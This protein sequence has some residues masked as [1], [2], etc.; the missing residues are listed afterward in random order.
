M[1]GKYRILIGG[2]PQQWCD[3][4]ATAFNQEKNFDV[5]ACI[6]S[7]ELV[8]TAARL[9]PDVVLWKVDSRN[10]L[11]GI[12]EIRAK[13]P[14]SLLVI[15]VRDPGEHNLLELVEAGVRGCLPLRLLPGQIVNAVE[16]I[17]VAGML[18]L[19]RFGPEFFDNHNNFTS[20]HTLLETLTKREREVLALLGKD[21]SNQAIASSL[22]LSESTVKSHLRSIFR[23]LGVRKRHEAQT[24]AIRNG[25]IDSGRLKNIS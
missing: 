4:L 17:V 21:L 24:V 10:I 3:C 13:T 5:L 9:Y 20:G 18:C 15:M 23:K 6:P 22:Y 14:F 25:L 16:L 12:S 2:N 11:E 7:R 8:E 19:P 1:M